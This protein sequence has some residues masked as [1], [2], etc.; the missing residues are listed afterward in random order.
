MPPADE[1]LLDAPPKKKERARPRRGKWPAP[2]SIQSEAAPPHSPI[3]KKK[4][5]PAKRRPNPSPVLWTKAEA[6]ARSARLLGEAGDWDGAAN[7]AYYAVFS[8]ARAVLASVR[9]SLAES[10]HHGTIFR[11]FE[12]HIVKGR[13]LDGALGHSFIGRLSGAR[14]A[15]DYG[16][17]RVSAPAAHA[18]VS[19]ADRFLAAVQPLLG[20][21]KR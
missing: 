5:E 14:R 10:R 13:G 1:T 21:A 17:D 9:A 12:K 11:R 3:A 19:D 20:K 18:M 4:P 2:A 7:R 15:A 8:A 6:A 16:N